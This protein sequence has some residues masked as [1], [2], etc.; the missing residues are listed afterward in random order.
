MP[1]RPLPRT[2]PRPRLHCRPRP[3]H[4]PAPAVLAALVMAAFLAPIAAQEPPPPPVMPPPSMIGPHTGPPPAPR[5]KPPAAP[6]K[7]TIA[8]KVWTGATYSFEGRV[9]TGVSNVTFEAPP[10]YQE[11]FGFWTN[12][13]KGSSRTELIQHLT[14]TREQATE[15]LLP[16]RRQVSRYNM[17]MNDHGQIKTAGGPFMKDVPTLAWEGSFD[18]H[19]NVTGMKRIAGPEDTAALDRLAFPLLDHLFPRLDGA[20]DITTGES[21]AQEMTMPLPSKLSIT[22]LE[23]TAAH[24]TRRYTLR[25]VRGQQAVF[26]VA[27]LYAVDPTTPP[28]APRTTCVITGGGEGEAVFDLTDGI[29]VSASQKTQLVIDVEAPLRHLPDQPPDADP[30]TAKSHMVINLSL[31]GKQK[32]ARLFDDAPPPEPA[33]PSD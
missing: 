5:P 7:V 23:S 25:E 30:G 32:M 19:G 1:P 29:F 13:M 27:L 24:L 2:P 12:R 9:E 21:F 10:A 28:T 31:S 26:D 4:P 20:R 18:A 22:G 15:G 33:P 14:T 8:P 3:A 11:S 17:D 16:F 6:V